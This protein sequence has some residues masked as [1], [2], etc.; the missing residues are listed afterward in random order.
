MKIETSKWNKFLV[1]IDPILFNNGMMFLSLTTTIPYF[2]LKFNAS[3]IHISIANLLPNLGSL[4]PVLFF[5]NYAQRLSRKGKAFTNMLL[6]QRVSFLIYVLLIPYL[7]NFGDRTNIYL[8]LTF[9]GIFS[10]FVG[11]YGPFYF[12]ILD[13]V[14]PYEER[15]N[16]LGFAYSVSNLLSLISSWVLGIYLAHFSFPHNFTYIFLTGILILIIDAFLFRLIR[17]PE[18]P[19]I[20]SNSVL[21]FKELITYA[22]D[23]LINNENFRNLMISFVLLFFATTTLPYHLVFITKTFET[24]SS[25]VS[26]MA[27]ISASINILGSL[28]F[29]RISKR[30]GNRIV[31]MLGNIM[32][33]IGIGLNFI[34]GS[35][36][37]AIICYALVISLF[38]A[39]MLTGG[40]LVTNI[41]K[42]EFLPFY[43]SVNTIVTTIFSSLLYLVNAK[44]MDFWGFKILILLGFLGSL[45]SFLILWRKMKGVK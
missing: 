31:L 45:G 37:A 39:Y 18:N 33:I 14:I 15:G 13:S 35:L 44:I 2:L 21:S 7:T 29:G 1:F 28:L 3:N 34:W 32:A 26:Q 24:T 30:F 25:I 43:I 19:N 17:E 42:R 10:F 12:S 5:A 20:S 9:W 36:S 8:F 6:I 27:L 4:I 23:L 16:I 40:L 11:S 38:N 22:K 41:A